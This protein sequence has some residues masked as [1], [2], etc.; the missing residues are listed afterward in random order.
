MAIELP[1]VTQRLTLRAFRPDDAGPLLA[2]YDDPDLAR[3]LLDEPWTPDVARERVDQRL[4][5]TGLDTESRTLCVA[6]EHGPTLIGDVTCWLNDATGRRAEISWVLATASSG[7]GYAAE[8]TTAVLDAV[9]AAGI[10][11]VEAQ[12]DARNEASAALAERLGMTREAH[13][14]QNWWIKGEWTDTLVYG[15]LADDRA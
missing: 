3:Y 4:G 15:L 14:R 12:M 2:V 13:L 9:F 5:Q 11:R 6:V 8:A 1:L 7:H 10:H